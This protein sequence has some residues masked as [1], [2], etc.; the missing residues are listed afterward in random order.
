MT[1]HKLETIVYL[2]LRSIPNKYHSSS[3]GLDVTGIRKNR[4]TGV[5]YIKLRIRVPAAAFDLFTAEQEIDLDGVEYQPVDP[6]VEV[7]PD[8]SQTG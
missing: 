8:A 6:T 1:G 2:T 3:A 5:P 4:P 7:L